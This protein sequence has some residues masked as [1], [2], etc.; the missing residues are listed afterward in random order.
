VLEFFTARS[1]NTPVRGL[2]HFSTTHTNV[3]GAL[4]AD[5]RTGWGADNACLS[6]E[7][8]E[9]MT[10]AFFE[11]QSELYASIPIGIGDMCAGFGWKEKEGEFAR[12]PDKDKPLENYTDDVLRWSGSLGS[13]TKEDLLRD[14]AE[15][16]S[17]RQ[18]VFVVLMAGRTATPSGRISAT[19]R[20]AAV[21]LR[22]AYTG[23][24]QVVSWQ[25]L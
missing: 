21:V 14:L 24:W 25:W 11:A 23:R 10:R 8:I 18:H 1:A 17:F 13:D 15:R 19:Q 4:M 3:V 22:D 12:S 16:I 20:A 7:G 5:L 2:V 9:W 6:D